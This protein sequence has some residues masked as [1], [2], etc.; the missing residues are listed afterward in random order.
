MRINISVL[1]RTIASI[2]IQHRVLE[3]VFSDDN[4][5]SKNDELI[6]ERGQFQLF[7]IFVGIR[8]SST[9]IMP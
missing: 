5:Y 8:I 4:V 7:L 3:V 9:Y 6:P 2:N 1:N